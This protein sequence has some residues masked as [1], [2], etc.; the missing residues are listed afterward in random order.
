MAG[1]QKDLSVPYQFSATTAKQR[2]VKLTGDQTVA[3]CAAITDVVV[4]VCEVGATAAEVTLGKGGSIIVDGVAWVEAEAAI[5]RGA[6]VGPSTSGRA[7]TA[8]STQFIAGRALKAAAAA[9]D[10]IPVLLMHASVALP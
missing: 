7:Q 3:Q 2:F 1:A 8:V 10:Y 5:T 4:G 6:F 9:G